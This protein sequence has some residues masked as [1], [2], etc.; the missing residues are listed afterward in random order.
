MQ[1]DNYCLNG[2]CLELY[3]MAG[4]ALIAD[5][6]YSDAS[7]TFKKAI[8]FIPKLKSASTR[9][10]F[11]ILFPVL[12]YLCLLIKA[13]QEVGLDYLK[14]Q[15]KKIDKAFFKESSHVKLVTEIT[16]ALRD[17]NL[18]YI[19]RVIEQ[20]NNYKFNEIAL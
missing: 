10:Y 18:N 20:L 3:R 9:D 13:K 11:Y 19:E 5:R 4:D 8:E 16:L 1:K 12:S 14:K 17:N 7:N 6:K 15:Q 2:H